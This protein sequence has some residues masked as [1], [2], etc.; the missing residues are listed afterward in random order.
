MIWRSSAPLFQIT[1]LLICSEVLLK[2]S[3]EVGQLPVGWRLG[4]L[5]DLNLTQ[6]NAKN[7]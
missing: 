4:M 1:E 6:L 2:L 7:L 3:T 5:L